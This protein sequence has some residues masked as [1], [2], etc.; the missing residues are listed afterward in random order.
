[1]CPLY[2]CL[3]RLNAKF[4][5]FDALEGEVGDIRSSPRWRDV[6]LLSYEDAKPWL[7]DMLEAAFY[8]QQQGIVHLD[9]KL[10][11]MLVN[12][13]GHIT[14]CDFGCAVHLPEVRCAFDTKAI[15]IHES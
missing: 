3:F 12:R 10:N 15:V 13:D 4:Y 14:L 7:R 8:L 1:M 9:I 6:P 2:A 5:V 11:N